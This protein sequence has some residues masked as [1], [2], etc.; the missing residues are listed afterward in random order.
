MYSSVAAFKIISAFMRTIQVQRSPKNL[1]S[2]CSSIHQIADLVIY[3]VV[4]SK[5]KCC[6]AA[7]Y[8]RMHLNHFSA[9][10]GMNQVSTYTDTTF[11]LYYILITQIL[12]KW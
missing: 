10:S 11:Y 3:C 6:D 5:I 8:T 4:Y 12:N 7:L 1:W 2:R 9:D